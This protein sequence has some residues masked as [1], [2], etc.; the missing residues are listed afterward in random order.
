MPNTANVLAGQGFLD[1][2]GKTIEKSPNICR[3]FAA[4]IGKIT[5]M[6]Q[7]PNIPPF[8]Q[9]FFGREDGAVTVDYV[10]I[11]GAVIGLGLAV[12]G[13]VA[14]G[15][16][17]YGDAISSY[18][19]NVDVSDGAS[20]GS[21]VEA[22][23]DNSS[24]TSTDSSSDSSSDGNSSESDGSDDGS[25]DSSSSDGNS[26]DSS[27]SD[28]SSGGSG[29]GNPGN[30]KDVGNAGETP[31]GSDNWGSGSNGVSS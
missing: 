25:S 24:D 29:S 1:H 4:S 10:V 21:D 15:T 7:L 3:I 27:S 17:D 11:L 30:D 13:S 22:T 19:L 20:D 2:A 26:G 28:N 16:I 18:L 9:R 14:S 31:N 6:R 23:D 5:P 8:A 12:T